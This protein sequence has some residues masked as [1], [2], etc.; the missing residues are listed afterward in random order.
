M[1]GEFAQDRVDR[2]FGADV[3]A[4]GGSVEDEDGGLGG[5]PLGQH[6]L[7]LVAA[8][9]GVDGVGGV[10][11]DDVEALHPLLLFVADGFLIDESEGLGE[12]FHF[13]DRDVF[14]DR[15]R[16]EEAF[17]ESVFGDVGDAGCDRV[18]HASQGDVLAFDADA[19]GVEGEHPEEGHGEFG[20]SGAQQAG[21]A[22]DFAGPHAQRGVGEGAGNGCTLD[23]EDRGL[24]DVAGPERSSSKSRPVMWRAKLARS[25]LFFRAGNDLVS[26]S[27]DGEALRD[28]EDFFELVGHEEDCDA[29]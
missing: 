21:D 10:G 8:R 4:D 18:A 6:D 15:A 24:G 17:G 2:E 29:A 27:Q 13:G 28:F 19:P 25:Q 7:L 14:A 12:G 1:R 23:L 9:Q 3:D 11:G 22:E 26:A 5:K 20:A 16:E